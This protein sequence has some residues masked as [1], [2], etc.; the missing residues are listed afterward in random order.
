[1]S[2]P[3]EIKST[4]VSEIADLK[5]RMNTIP[6]NASKQIRTI[7]KSDDS[8]EKKLTDRREVK[9]TMKKELFNTKQAI[10]EKNKALDALNA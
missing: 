6:K 10:H 4:I 2:S 7:L 1:M 9:K 8:D 3:A 5:K